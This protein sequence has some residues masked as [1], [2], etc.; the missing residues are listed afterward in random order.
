MHNDHPFKS[1]A[2]PFH[3]PVERVDILFAKSRCV[4]RCIGSFAPLPSVSIG[5]VS[6]FS[7]RKEA[8]AAARSCD[9]FMLNSAVPRTSVC[10][11]RKTRDGFCS[12]NAPSNSR[13]ASCPTLVKFV[14][15]NSKVMGT[16]IE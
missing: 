9:N 10:P 16:G 12:C 2:S 13:A 11:M 14:V 6:P 15:P 5:T 8:T 1:L 4:G 7:C 3:P